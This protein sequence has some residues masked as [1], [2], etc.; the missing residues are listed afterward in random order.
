MPKKRKCN[1][2]RF[3]SK[4]IR[5]GTVLGLLGLA[6]DEVFS[7]LDFSSTGVLNPFVSG[8]KAYRNTVSTDTNTR[9]I[10]AGVAYIL[11]SSPYGFRKAGR[12]RGRDAKY[13]PMGGPM[14]KQIA[15]AIPTCAN[16]RERVAGVVISERIA[17]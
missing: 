13:A 8:R 10:I 4:L 9:V 14:Q 5:S 6:V 16:V 17:L 1:S 2:L 12:G 3:P 15:N 7:V 11:S